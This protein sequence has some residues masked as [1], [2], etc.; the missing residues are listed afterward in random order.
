ME[1]QEKFLNMRKLILLG[2]FCFS[3]NL[4]A[5]KVQ[6]VVFVKHD[7]LGGVYGMDLVDKLLKNGWIVKKCKTT[8]NGTGSLTVFVFSTPKLSESEYKRKT[9]QIQLE[10]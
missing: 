8:S 7:L 4:S 5:Q 9:G 1:I 6:T 10:K 2:L 3:L